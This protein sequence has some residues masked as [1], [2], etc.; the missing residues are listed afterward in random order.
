MNPLIGFALAHAEQASL[1]HLERV[2]LYIG[3]NKEQP[4]FRGRQGAVLI[5][6]K[7]ASGPGLAIEAPRCHMLLEGRLEGRK[8]L[9]KLVEGQAG[10]IQELRGAGLHI[11]KPDTGHLWCLLSWEA[12]YTIIGI[13]SINPTRR[14]PN[15]TMHDSPRVAPP[16][17][18]HTSSA[19][20][21]AS[22]FAVSLW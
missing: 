18:M 21:V 8:Q 6:A 2:S 20:Q 9:L 14:K 19:L 5:H 22:A 3:Q 4:V 16:F 7:L 17:K 1:H 13:N 15:L 10:E 12:Q 11:G